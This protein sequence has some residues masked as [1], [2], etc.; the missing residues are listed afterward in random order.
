MQTFREWL[1][2][3]LVERSWLAADLTRASQSADFPRGLD[4]GLISRWRKPPPFGSVPTSAQTLSRIAAAFG[5]P[6]SEVY[7][8][9]GLLPGGPPV[10]ATDEIDAR[11]QAV[12]D[13]L[14]RW[15][16]AVGP[17]H[18]EAFWR[19]LKDQG[20][21]TVRLIS[22]VGTAVNQA[23]DAAVNAAVSDRAERGR[24]RRRTSDGPLTAT[25]HAPARRVRRP[26]AAPNQRL[27]A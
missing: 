13:Q 25:Q 3:Q 20:D 22:S 9:A 7:A 26:L 23:G 18:E 11:R 14:D 21:S 15:L 2:T 27:A 4:S 24:R 17:E 5:L 6:E 16:S 8:A 1:D 12:R 19:Y 10:D